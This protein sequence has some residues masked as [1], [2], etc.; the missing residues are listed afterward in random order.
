LPTHEWTYSRGAKVLGNL[1]SDTV[2]K[3]VRESVHLFRKLDAWC[4]DRDAWLK[5]KARGATKMALYDSDTG[6]VYEVSGEV[7]EERAQE[8]DY[9]HGVQWALARK[10]WRVT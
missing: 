10:H 2:Y 3:T 8:I 9:G 6:L 1:I 7:F 4:I 5:W